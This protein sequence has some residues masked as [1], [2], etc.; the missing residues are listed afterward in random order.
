MT[1]PTAGG[2]MKTVEDIIKETEGT[3]CPVRR[4]AYVVREFLAEP[5]C[6]RCFPCSMGSFEARLRLEALA[7]GEASAEDIAAIGKIASMMQAM[8]MC[9]KGKDVAAYLLGALKEDGFNEH[10]SGVCPS[11]ECPDLIEYRI[12]PGECI[13]C[14][15]CQDVCRYDAILGEKKKSVKCCFLPFEIR[16]KRCVKCGECIKACPTGAIRIVNIDT[17]KPVTT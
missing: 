4:S 3:R 5:M 2:K 6:G 11:K 8:S 9:K 7:A 13:L 16:Q 14:G 12:T 15:D 17:K 10:A 1:N